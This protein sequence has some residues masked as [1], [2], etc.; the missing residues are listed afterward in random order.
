MT[1]RDASTTVL[2]RGVPKIVD[3][4]QRR[5][6]LAEAVWRVIRRE[7]VEH[8]SVR[9]VA[10]EAGCSTGSLRHYFASQSE[11]LAF[12]MRLVMEQV[13]SRVAAVPRPDD[14]LAAAKV[15]LAE[16]LPLDDV[17]NAENQVWVAF[18]ARALV[19][20][21]LRD[22]RDLA[23]D[24]LREAAG[25]WVDHLLPGADPREHRFETER[26]FALMDGLA[27]HA[28]MRPELASPERLAAVLEQHLDR[29]VSQP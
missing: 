26:L 16:L 25:V 1:Q 3:R 22:L 8:A 14:P 5:Q 2:K 12:A 19:D 21:E 11:L 13:E 18:T 6:E 23:F 17:R 24:R 7:G 28:A 15:V 9:A 29:I 27:L 20:D 4:V 10:R